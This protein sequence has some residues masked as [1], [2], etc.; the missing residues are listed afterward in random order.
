MTDS[1][2]AIVRS[3]VVDSVE[4]G[5]AL[6]SGTGLPNQLGAALPLPQFSTGLATAPRALR[7]EALGLL[8]QLVVPPTTW[9][10]V[11]MP[12]GEQQLYSPGSYW[13]WGL[14]GAVVAQW[15]DAR[16]QQIPVGPVE[17]WSADKWRVRLWV[18]VEVVVRNPVAVAAQSEPLMALAAAARSAALRF[19]EQHSH[20]QLTGLDG[21]H[22]GLDAPT[23]AI[24]EHLRSDNA[25]AELEII[26]V[27]VIE[28][29]GDERQIEAI[30]TATVAAAQID[31]GR[32]VEAARHRAR[33]QDIEGQAALSEREHAL[34][35]AAVAAQA[36]ERLLA[37]QSEVQQAALAAR[38]EVV[39][40]QIRA[41][42]AEI[43]HDEQLWQAEQ[44]RLQSGWERTQHQLLGAHEADLQLRRLDAQH[45]LARSEGKLALAAQERQHTYGLA[46]AEAQGRIAEQL[47]E[48]TERV[49][50]RRAQHEH[51][52]LELHLRHE[53]LVAEQLQ[54]LEY[55]HA[56]AADSR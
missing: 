35:L 12:G 20:A 22:G 16:R 51:A 56:P 40:A 41:Q 33:M 54:K 6:L 17:G 21:E 32:R 15:V 4:E 30:T 28:R 3:A 50:E 7:R 29:Q 38:L 11:H 37:Q 44:A 2:G 24:G 14:P 53:A 13:L 52:L 55:W 10:V 39:M 23:E 42:V 46:L 31:E 5:L 48:Q 18:I 9:A 26:S 27:R 49:A 45:G 19:M 47:V 1:M 8:T 36:R 25:L 43:A 34:R